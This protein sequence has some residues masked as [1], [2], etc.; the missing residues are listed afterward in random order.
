MVQ[1]IVGT[2]FWK[3][4]YTVNVF[5]CGLQLD[6]DSFLLNETKHKSRCDVANLHI[7]VIVVSYLH[8]RM[9]ICKKSNKGVNLRQYMR[10]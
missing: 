1:N 10:D 9:H 3:C 7:V 2:Y 6:H 8:I 5:Q 4:W